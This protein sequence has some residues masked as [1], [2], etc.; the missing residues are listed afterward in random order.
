MENLLNT[1]NNA[2]RTSVEGKKNGQTQH[3]GGDDSS[4]KITTTIVTNE[5]EQQ[6]LK[7]N[8]RL[9]NDPL[10]QQQTSSLP[11][12]HGPFPKNHYNTGCNGI[13][14][15]NN[16]NDDVVVSAPTTLSPQQQKSPELI[17]GVGELTGP[18]NNSSIINTS[19]S[20][21][22]SVNNNHIIKN[23]DYNTN[24]VAKNNNSN[25]NSKWIGTKRNVS[26]PEDNSI[27]TGFSEP[28]NPWKN[29]MYA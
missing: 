28:C 26:F 18:S 17:L 11:F 2:N 23:P 22:N 24:H 12:D 27:V 21:S 8:I 3:L 9:Y 1:A 10:T 7:Q 20:T 5:S 13:N 6:L 29:G 14:N 4:C 16:N 19:V 25:N 15:N